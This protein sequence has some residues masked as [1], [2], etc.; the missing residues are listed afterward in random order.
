[1]VGT[2]H[3]DGYWVLRLLFVPTG[4]V[5]PRSTD[6]WVAHAE[7]LH[8][9]FRVAGVLDVCGSVNWW[10][11]PC[12]T[13]LDGFRYQMGPSSLVGA[14]SQLECSLQSVSGAQSVSAV[15]TTPAMTSFPLLVGVQRF[16]AECCCGFLPASWDAVTL[17]PRK[18]LSKTIPVL[19]HKSSVKLQRPLK[20]FITLQGPPP[21]PSCQAPTTRAQPKRCLGQMVG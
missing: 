21:G 19:C 12:W 9:G 17:P 18:Q 1:M 2:D 15:N 14:D 16:A 7:G 4:A 20:P 10:V 13:G 5:Q 8:T 6:Q 11:L 3:R